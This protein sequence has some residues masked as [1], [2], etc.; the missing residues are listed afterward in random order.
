MNRRF[1]FLQSAHGLTQSLLSMVRV[2][3]KDAVRRKL[4]S[5]ANPLRAVPVKIEFRFAQIIPLFHFRQDFFPQF[6]RLFAVSGDMEYVAADSALSSFFNAYYN[7]FG[8]ESWAT[9]PASFRLRIRLQV[10]QWPFSL[11]AA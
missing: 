1:L 7:M 5:G 3:D 8:L 9:S 10:E 11:R 4:Q 2:K 6:L